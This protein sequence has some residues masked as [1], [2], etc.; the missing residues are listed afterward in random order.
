MNHSV[1]SISNGNF[2]KLN[3]LVKSGLSCVNPLAAEMLNIFLIM[4]E[5]LKLKQEKNSRFKC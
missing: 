1:I 3:F 4:R 5:L 2:F